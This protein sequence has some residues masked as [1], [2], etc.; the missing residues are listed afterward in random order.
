MRRLFLA[1]M[2]ALALPLGAQAQTVEAG[3]AKFDS[4]ADVA[5]TKLVINGAG[6]R[7]RAV[8]KVYAVALYVPQR[9]STPEALIG[10]AGPKRVSLHMLRDV[11][12]KDLGKAFTDAMEKNMLPEERARSINGVFK[13][14]QVFSERKKLA[15]GDIV[16][17]DWVPNVGAQVFVDGK[18][19][20]DVIKEPEFYNS[21]LRIW[22]GA[23]P[24][25][26]ELKEQLLGQG[27]K[28]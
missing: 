3:G 9:G 21:L 10:Q 19:V 27:K 13:F 1:S 25:S 7:F 8:F 4:T 6:V 28:R 23:N 11:D 22:L 12:G 17:V 26:A 5:G 20:G 24:P 16:N 18:A 2:L 15:S 14:G